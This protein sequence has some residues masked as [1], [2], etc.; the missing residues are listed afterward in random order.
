MFYESRMRFVPVT[1]DGV[2]I[3]DRVDTFRNSFRYPVSSGGLQNLG[4]FRI[5][6]DEAVVIIGLAP[7]PFVFTVTTLAI[8]LE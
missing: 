8:L 6:E 2:D 3:R 4:L 7:L 5:R 1:L